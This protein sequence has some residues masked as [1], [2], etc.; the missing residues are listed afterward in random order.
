MTILELA[1]VAAAASLVLGVL[2]LILYMVLTRQSRQMRKDAIAGADAS[3]RQD[4]R[5]LMDELGHLAE[6]IDLR[7]DA[8]I[9][10]LQEAMDRAET[11]LQRLGS[12]GKGPDYRPIR[13]PAHGE[14]LRLDGQGLDSI[15]IA[16]RME[17]DVGEVELVLNL[18]RSGGDAR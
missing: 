16:R 7:M 9:Q 14:I 15:E 5:R 10:E 2:L 17:M 6:Q 1:A 18:N 13:D 12:G 11:T 4:V 8:R 3:M